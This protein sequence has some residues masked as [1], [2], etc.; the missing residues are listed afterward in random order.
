MNRF[1]KSL[2]TLTLVFAFATSGFAGDG[3]LDFSG[4]IRSRGFA[5]KT[6]F[7]KD[8]DFN[9]YDLLRSRF[10]VSA[11]KDDNAHAF[12]QFQDSRRYGA[13][14]QSGSLSSTANVDIHQA[15][16]KI[17]NLFGEGWGAQA[18]RFEFSKGNERVFGAYDWDNVGRSWEGG[19]FWYDNDEMNINLYSLKMTEDSSAPNQDFDVVGIYATV[20]SINLDVFVNWDKDADS[21]GFAS[22]DSTALDRKSFGA[23]YERMYEQFDFTLNYVL[24]T[25]SME[26]TVDISAYMLAFE[27]SYSMED[28]RNTRI[29]FG[30]DMASGSDTA[31]AAKNEWNAYDNL[32]YTGHKFR[33]EM[34]YFLGNTFDGIA[35]NPGLRDIYLGASTEVTDGWKI[36]AKFHM[37]SAAQDYVDFNGDLTSDVGSEFDIMISTSRVAGV[38]LDW[39]ISSFSAKD[40]FVGTTDHDSG[41]WAY[42]TATIEF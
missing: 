40:S 7:A 23:Y 39:V 16:I 29:V 35:G 32:Y 14:T 22:K 30:I 12:V 20:K 42:G 15:Y 19:Q 25:G 4:Q 17:D 13:G 6:T 38:K 33:G 9:T 11:S 28:D 34:D 18:G 27:V 8:A 36:G 1:M 3:E 41:A 24:Q 2:I 10:S 21:S 26:D 31:A 37:F 5:D